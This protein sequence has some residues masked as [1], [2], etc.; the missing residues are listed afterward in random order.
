MS[1]R[2]VTPALL[3]GHEDAARSMNTFGDNA[4][5][6]AI[7]EEQDQMSNWELM[8]KQALLAAPR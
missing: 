1:V 5:P 4:G 2:A 6:A 3:G 8:T 7:Y